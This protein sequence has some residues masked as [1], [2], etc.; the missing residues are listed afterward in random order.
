M[1]NKWSAI[2]IGQA[3]GAI[4]A[5]NDHLIIYVSTTGDDDTGD[6]SLT[7]PYATP[8]KAMEH[9]RKFYIGEDGKVTIKCAAGEYTFSKTLHLNHPQGEK[10]HLVGDDPLECGH[11]SNTYNYTVKGAYGVT[12]GYDTTKVGGSH[13]IKL[14]M[15]HPVSG[16]N[17]GFT[18][19]HGLT[20]GHVG[21]WLQVYPI[22]LWGNGNVDPGGQINLPPTKMR[23]YGKAS[24]YDRE[25]GSGNTSGGL[26]DNFG[27]E[28]DGTGSPGGSGGMQWRWVCGCSKI[29]AVTGGAAR[30][31]HNPSGNDAGPQGNNIGSHIEINAQFM[32]AF[33]EPRI[34]AQ[35]AD[36]PA[37]RR[38]YYNDPQEYADNVNNQGG[39]VNSDTTKNIGLISTYSIPTTDGHT[40][41]FVASTPDTIGARVL[42]TTFKWTGYDEWCAVLITDN[43]TFG[44]FKNIVFLN[45]TYDTGDISRTCIG[46]DQN[47]ILSPY[48]LTNQDDDHI[49]NN[50]DHSVTSRCAFLN[51][52]RPIDVWYDS[53]ATIRQCTMGNLTGLI[54]YYDSCL[55]LHS[56]VLS[57][58][59]GT[60]VSSQYAS[61]INIAN[62]LLNNAFYQTGSIKYGENEILPTGEAGWEA[63][64]YIVQFNSEDNNGKFRQQGIITSIRPDDRY[65]Y[66]KPIVDVA[67]GE[68]NPPF[69]DTNFSQSKRLFL[70]KPGTAWENLKTE[71]KNGWT[72]VDFDIGTQVGVGDNVGPVYDTGPP[73]SF[74]A[75]AMDGYFLEYRSLSSSDGRAVGVGSSSL[76]TMQGCQVAGM[77]GYGI[78]GSRNTTAYAD[79]CCFSGIKNHA[80]HTWMNCGLNMR[81]S[82]CFHLRRAQV[83][84]NGSIVY[85][86]NNF[87]TNMGNST[88]YVSSSSHAWSGY[89]DYYVGRDG[90][91]DFVHDVYS[92]STFTSD[93]DR[94]YFP[95]FSEIDLWTR[96]VDGNKIPTYSSGGGGARYAPSAAYPCANP[97]IGSSPYVIDSSGLR[98][99]SAALFSSEI[100]NNVLPLNSTSEPVPEFYGLHSDNTTVGSLAFSVLGD[101]FVTHADDDAIMNGWHTKIDITSMTT[102]NN[103]YGVPY[104]YR[105][106]GA[107]PLVHFFN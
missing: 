87:F 101:G 105:R 53:T 61:S 102:N 65:I 2:D 70:V 38:S 30:L 62:S 73:A 18:T 7:A 48:S 34:K 89:N 14:L 43:K 99:D 27:W 84:A 64:D 51:W 94:I 17:S 3:P 37:H 58:S 33:I 36:N 59:I 16:E 91:S 107:V 4:Q 6:G 47:S 50:D 24:L 45:Y 78:V 1:A 39:V 49:W 31:H 41:G 88:T 85:S 26:S 86:Y 56:C 25:W 11:P 22:T 35:S 10:I 82:T 97:N 19:E 75:G 29:T 72:T 60:M 104:T 5:V 71:V 93:D 21:S 8:H 95:L 52:S 20:K 69:F 74:M 77:A 15:G 98:P 83:A 42:K 90:M 54:A 79:D 66:F 92:G 32:S 46:V 28:V 76:A 12:F 68:T 103:E 55:K 100:N 80:M 23:T 81:D 57:N 40:S 44:S 106:S 63:G 13:K 67:E 96:P 9:V